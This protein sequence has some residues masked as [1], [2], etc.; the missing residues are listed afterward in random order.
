M[1]RYLPLQ[2]YCKCGCFS[3]HLQFLSVGTDSTRD[4]YTYLAT[5]TIYD[6]QLLIKS[7]LIVGFGALNLVFVVLG[8]HDQV[9]EYQFRKRV[10]DMVLVQVHVAS[11]PRHQSC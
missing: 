6:C 5:L 8:K 10:L 7:T 1:G 11:A 9:L 4:L 2:L 3:D